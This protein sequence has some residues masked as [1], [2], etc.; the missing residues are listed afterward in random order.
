MSNN[1]TY[2]DDFQELLN[3][4][5]AKYGEAI[6]IV[7]AIEELSELQTELCHHLRGR[8]S[9][10]TEEMADTIL[11]LRQLE[12]IFDNYQQVDRY[13]QQKLERL[14]RRLEENDHA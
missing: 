3:A 1:I 6:L 13:V 2:P 8:G 9:N 5:V 14:R 7:L 11:M 10:V 4:A 12:N